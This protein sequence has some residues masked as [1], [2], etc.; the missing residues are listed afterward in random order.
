MKLSLFTA[1][2]G[3]LCGTVV[4]EDTLSFELQDYR[5]KSHR[6]SDYDQSRVVVLAFLGTECPLVRLYG[7]VLQRM[8]QTYANQGVSFLAVNPNRQD[9]ITEI[10]AFARNSGISFPILKDV[11]NRLA[12]RIGVT[13]TPEVVVLNQRREVV[14]LGR[15]DD[16]YGV[17]VKR[18]QASQSWLTDAIEAALRGDK[19]R[20]G[21]VPAEGCLIG[22]IL[23]GVTT[24]ATA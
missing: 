20:K 16:Q 18:V 1:L 10:A 9:S 11:G 6:L 23:G 8:S 21:R 24:L 2:L 19:P 22:A 12:D 7:P 13:R 3:L 14:Y 17:G 5:G 4:A 15:I